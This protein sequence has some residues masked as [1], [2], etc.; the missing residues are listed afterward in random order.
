MAQEDPSKERSLLMDVLVR[1]SLRSGGSFKLSSGGEST[2]YVDVKQTAFVAR[3]MPLIGRAFLRKIAERGW[4][5][6]AVGG[7]TLGADPIAVSIARESLDH[8]NKPIDAF[9]VRKEPKGHGTKRSIEGVADPK[10]MRVVIIEDVCTGGGSTAD[11]IDK[12]RDAGMEVLGAICLVDR[13][14]GATESLGEKYGCR[15]ESIFKLSE[16]EAYRDRLEAS[17]VPAGAHS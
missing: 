14:Q 8:W 2:V 3:A 4:D 15:L 5:P 9:T 10:G 7:R 6:E 16:L 17:P 11:A 12:A 1:R 13:E